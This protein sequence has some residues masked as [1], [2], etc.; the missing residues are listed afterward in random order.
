M[1]QREKY[2]TTPRQGD[3]VSTAFVESTIN[4]VVSKRFIKKQQMRWSQKREH[5]LLA[6]LEPL[7]LRASL[8]VIGEH[9]PGT[10]P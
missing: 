6:L 7:A 1:K 10:G 2:A 5:L 4:Q 9:T 3:T 8:P